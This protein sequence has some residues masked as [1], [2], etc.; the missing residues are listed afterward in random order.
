MGRG[1]ARGARPGPRPLPTSSDASSAAS[2][3]TSPWPGANGPARPLPRWVDD[4]AGAR[5]SA[6]PPTQRGG[7]SRGGAGALAVGQCPRGPGP[8]PDPRHPPPAVGAPAAQ[9][10]R[11]P[12]ARAPSA[13]PGQTAAPDDCRD[14]SGT[15]GLAPGGS[16]G[17]PTPPGHPGR[18]WEGRPSGRGAVTAPAGQPNGGAPRSTRRCPPTPRRRRRRPRARRPINPPGWATREL[19]GAE[20]G[21]TL[22]RRQAPRVRLPSWKATRALRRSPR[23]AAAPAPPAP[24]PRSSHPPPLRRPAPPRALDPAQGSGP[25][26]TRARLTRRPVGWGG[27]CAGSAADAGPRQRPT[28]AGSGETKESPTKP[29]KP[30]TSPTPTANA[31]RREPARASPSAR[32]R[33]RLNRLRRRAMTALQAPSKRPREPHSAGAARLVGQP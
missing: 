1:P 18:V 4:S 3:S 8:L 31:T 9:P 5:P 33:P 16:Q 28:G 15:D 27:G 30:D 20:R 6:P 11:G 32:G 14:G 29:D 19:R 17:S 23:H 13:G 12:S 2:W 26:P 10:S 7:P 22:P 25:L 24:G 21:P